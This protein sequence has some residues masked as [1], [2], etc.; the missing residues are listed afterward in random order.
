M[1]DDKHDAVVRVGLSTS[2]SQTV[3]PL[4]TESRD[5][6]PSV[7][8]IGHIQRASD[9]TRED[10]VTV[11]PAAALQMKTDH[12]FTTNYINAPG[13]SGNP[14]FGLWVPK[15]GRSELLHPELYHWGWSGPSRVLVRRT[16]A[17]YWKE[18]YGEAKESGTL[19]QSA[20]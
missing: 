13:D 6:K 3:A 18:W 12:A 8:L 15:Q 5:R 1:V 7:F 16:P 14:A 9:G 19:D 10:S 17:K 4:R 2:L 20:S 11:L